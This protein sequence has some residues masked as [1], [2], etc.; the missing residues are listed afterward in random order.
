MISRYVIK[1]TV[2]LLNNFIHMCT[3]DQFQCYRIII[4]LEDLRRIS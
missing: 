1:T 2:Y 3:Y 4:L